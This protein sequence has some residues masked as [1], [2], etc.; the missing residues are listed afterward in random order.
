MTT[1]SSHKLTN[2]NGDLNDR[3]KA[4]HGLNFQDK[5]T[6]LLLQKVY[7]SE[8]KTGYTPFSGVLLDAIA[9]IYDRR[10]ISFFKKVA[11]SKKL[12]D[13]H[14][15]AAV[16]ELFELREETLQR[17]AP[18]DDQAYEVS[19]NTVITSDLYISQGAALTPKDCKT[20]ADLLHAWSNSKAIDKE[21]KEAA[22]HY[23]GQ[24]QR[25]E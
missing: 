10:N 1:A 15:T 24:M 4:M 6:L 2:V 22:I 5:Q 19:F 21:V 12:P 25:H 9:S 20:I 14:Q 3:I 18:P 16:R 17:L 13:I 7:L 8:A 11:E 23:Q